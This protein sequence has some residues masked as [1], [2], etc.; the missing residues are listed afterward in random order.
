MRATLTKGDKM[1]T[2]GFLARIYLDWRNNFLTPAVFA[3]H[4]GITEEE[5]K[6]LIELARSVF[7]SEHPDK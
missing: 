1:D 4:H 5:G 6:R 7:Y 3:E 2:R